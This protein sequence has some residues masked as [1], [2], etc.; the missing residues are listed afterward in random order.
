[1][2]DVIQFP[3]PPGDK[4][5]A[6]FDRIIN[7]CDAIAKLLPPDP[8]HESWQARMDAISL[9]LTRTCARLGLDSDGRPLP[10]DHTKLPPN[11]IPLIR[12]KRRRYKA[13]STEPA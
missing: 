11:V 10:I 7:T 4:G 8:T 12:Q 1:M 13:P 9:S 3:A 6:A 5:H 2:G